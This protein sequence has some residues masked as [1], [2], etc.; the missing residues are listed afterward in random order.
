[1]RSCLLSPLTLSQHGEHDI[2]DELEFSNHKGYVF[3]DPRG[4]ECGATMELDILRGF[5]QRN[6]R[7]ALA[8]RYARL[9]Q[10]DSMAIARDMVRAG[11]GELTWTL[12]TV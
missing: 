1:M 11:Y 9:V 7:F 6:R 8:L 3:R 4:I 12:V 10:T 5:I 2:D